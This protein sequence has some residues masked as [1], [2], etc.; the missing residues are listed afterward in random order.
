MPQK[1]N[2]HMTVHVSLPPNI[3]HEVEAQASAKRISKS[4]RIRQIVCDYVESLGASEREVG[5]PTPPAPRTVSYEVP[6]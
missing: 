1:L 2:T 5:N 6:R 3:F 4:A